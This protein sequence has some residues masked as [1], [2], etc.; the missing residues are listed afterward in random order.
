MPRRRETRGRAPVVVGGD[1]RLGVALGGERRA[2]LREL[3]AQLQVVVD[4]AVEDDRVTIVGPYGPAERLVRVLHVD[5]RQPVEPEHDVRVVPS[6]A[7][8]RSAVPSAAHRLPDGVGAG[9]RVA[10]RR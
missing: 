1:D 2:Q 8:V 7:F 10:R 5:D 4:L 9:G 3:G 6:A